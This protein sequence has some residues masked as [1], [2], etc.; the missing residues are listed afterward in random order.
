MKHN[1]DIVVIG[2][3][4][5]GQEVICDLAD[6]LP[7]DLP[8]SILVVLHTSPSSPRLLADIVRQRTKLKVSYAE[9]G[10]PLEKSHI[11]LAPPDLH[12]AVVRPGNLVLR[13]TEKVCF[14]RPSADVL[15][16]SAAENFGPRVIGI[17]L[18]GG[19]GDGVAGLRAIHAAG[20]IAMVQDPE[21]ALAPEMP[22]NALLKDH[23]DFRVS[24]QAMPSLVMRPVT[25]PVK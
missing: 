6:Q 4:R 13:S 11:Y 8:A 7:S 25:D 1:R 3:S 5:G 21:E 15:F 10:E 14:C 19:D 16:Q 9:Q 22:M 24:M 2:P 17:V 23:L 20:G 18:T 12:L